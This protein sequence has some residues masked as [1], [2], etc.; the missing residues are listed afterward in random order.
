MEC[1]ELVKQMR[2]M[3][4]FFQ[5]KQNSIEILLPILLSALFSSL[6]H[7]ELD[8]VQSSPF[9]PPTFDLIIGARSL[10]KKITGPWTF[11]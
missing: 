11:P 2:G 8:V 1:L 6:L 4:Y 5:K 3:Y 10:I 9:I 7:L